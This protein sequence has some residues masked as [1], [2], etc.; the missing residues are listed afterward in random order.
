MRMFDMA[1]D[2]GLFHTRK[3]LESTGWML[4]GNRFTR[5]DDTMLPLYEAKMIHHFDDRLGT[6]EG[7]TQ[8]Q[9]NMGTLPRL[10]ADQKRDPDY[11]VLPRYWVAEG[12]VE[13]RLQKRWGRKWLIGLRDICRSTDERTAI[14]GWIS[15]VGTGNTWPIMVSPTE[16]MACLYA[17]MSA[18]VLDYCLRQK[19]GGTHLTYGYLKQLP[20]LQPN[21]YDHAAPWRVGVDLQNWLTSRVV[22]LVCTTWEMAVA[23]ESGDGAPPFVWNEQRRFT[24]RAE[25][26][27]A[28]FHL[29]GVER[30]DVDYI[31]ETFP[32]VKKKDVAAFGSYR[33]KELILEVYDAM[34]QAIRTG[35]P[36]KTIL[37]PPPGEAPP[38]RVLSLVVRRTQGPPAGTR[39]MPRMA[40]LVGQSE[41]GRREPCS[42]LP[43]H[44]DCAYRRRSLP[45]LHARVRYWPGSASPA[46]SRVLSAHSVSGRG[47][48]GYMD[49][50]GPQ[51][52]PMETVISRSETELRAQRQRLLERAGI[53]EDELR[54]RA[55][56]YQLTAEQMD[57]LTTIDNIDFLLGE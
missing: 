17:N 57:V 50:H 24:I 45:M 20:V 32:I 31:M 26:D 30:D 1:N 9:A 35:E 5:G 3:E 38:P 55:E 29:Y 51:E 19:M 21:E 46:P 12:R 13:E 39:N 44:G 52:D 36:Y 42:A 8:A 28:Y 16:R 43:V 40:D 18:F 2:S 54:R 33:T 7:Q 23:S 22:E 11:A 27:A 48:T 49:D 37:D 34:A 56:N 47:L 25:L 41:V 10:S 4:Q 15:R 6:Y 14:F 53:N